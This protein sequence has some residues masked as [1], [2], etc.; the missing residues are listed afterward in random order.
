MSETRS[1]RDD[2]RARLAAAT[3]DERV[4][5][6]EQLH[7]MLTSVQAMLTDAITVA[8]DA[9]DWEADGARD[10][11]GW[12][13]LRLGVGHH[14]AKSLSGLAERLDD[15]PA[16]AD[17]FCDGTYSIDQVKQLVRFA[18]PE[19]EE[20]LVEAC[21]GASV[22]Q[23][24]WMARNAE[25]RTR[26][27]EDHDHRRRRLYAERD[28]QRLDI[29]GTCYGRQ[30]ENIRAALDYYMQFVPK[31]PQTGDWD[32]YPQRRADALELIC[33]N[34]LADVSEAPRPTLVVHTSAERLIDEAAGGF[35]HFELGPAV[36]PDLARRLARDCYL[37]LAA[38]DADGIT[39]AISSRARTVPPHMARVLLHRDG[40]CRFPGCG[41]TRLLEFHHVRPWRETHHTRADEIATF[42]YH[43]HDVVETKGW[44]IRGDPNDTLEFIRPDGTTLTSGPKPLTPQL[45]TYLRGGNDP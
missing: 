6:I 43:H 33:L 28:G 2:F 1:F 19:T 38:D 17:A 27:D 18:T 3:A 23:L 21:R 16:I 29:D 20:D 37:Q 12:L 26:E 39:R 32:P 34:A 41:G 31:N 11:A 42:C 15:L 5:T 30:G 4:E 7:A 40:G 9:G 8:D 13:A 14:N 35:A 22:K 10:M 45:K 44:T 36:S 25:N 24:S